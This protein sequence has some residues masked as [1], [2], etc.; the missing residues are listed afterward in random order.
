[1]ILAVAVFA[2][3]VALSQGQVLFDAQTCAANIQTSIQQWQ[4]EVDQGLSTFSQQMQ[5]RTN[6]ALDTTELQGDINSMIREMTGLLDLSQGIEPQKIMQ[7]MS[8]MSSTYFSIMLKT[9]RISVLTGGAREGTTFMS[10]MANAQ[11]KLVSTLVTSCMP[12][13]RYQITSSPQ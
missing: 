12:A 8:R 3:I 11:S 10:N 9:M 13:N 5:Q 1:M 6:Q 2:G 7:S 4:R